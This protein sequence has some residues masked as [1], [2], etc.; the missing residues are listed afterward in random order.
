MY[1]LSEEKRKGTS[2]TKTYNYAIINRSRDVNCANVTDSKF[3]FPRYI[4]DIPLRK[5]KHTHTSGNNFCREEKSDTR[6]KRRQV[7]LNIKIH[8]FDQKL[9]YLPNRAGGGRTY[10]VKL[11]VGNNSHRTHR[12]RLRLRRRDCASAN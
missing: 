11:S 4:N 3:I 10:G 6:V 9:I 8:L 7:R 12:V 2:P 5:K 1:H